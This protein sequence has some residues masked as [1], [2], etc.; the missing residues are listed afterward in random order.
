M[1]EKVIINPITRISGFMQIEVTIEKNTVIDARNTGFLFRGFEEMLK[2]RSP[3]DSIYFTERICG[4][5]STAHGFVAATAL[6]DALKV[7]P[8]ENGSILRQIMHGCE[9]LQNHIRHFYQFTVPDYVPINVEPAK[10]IHGIRYKLP[11]EINERLNNHYI[12]SFKFSRLG[13]KMLALLGGKAPHAHGIFVGGATVNIDAS[14]IIELK[15][16]MFS[17][18]DFAQNIMLE[19]ANIIAKYYPEDFRNGKSYGNFL[20]YGAFD[21]P[22]NTPKPYV[23]SGVIIN[24]VRE[25]FD[26]NKIDEDIVYSYYSDTKAVLTNKDSNWQPDTNK[27]DAYTWIKAARYKGLPMEVGPLARL[28]INGEYTSGIA[29]LDRTMARVIELI[30]VCDIVENLI[31]K[32][33]LKPVIQQKWEIPEISSGVG[34]RDTTRGA[35]AHWIS[36]E[37]KKIKNYNIITPSGWNISPEDS[38]GNKGVIEK[39]LIGTYVEDAKNPFE[40]GRIIR[41]F[42]PCISCATHIISDRFEDFSM[43]IV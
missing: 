33:K 31:D 9:F 24:N 18:K 40:V 32:V 37:G 41:S 28:W 1:K 25:D 12:E 6:E 20:S 15:S 14:K 36:I 27:K 19:D 26:V 8:D 35:L 43:R 29:T 22:F 23:K 34:T 30:K 17:I 21:M 3:F 4:I 13:H 2:G 7:V 11:K 39:S 16:M 10:N 5:C 38:K 42:D